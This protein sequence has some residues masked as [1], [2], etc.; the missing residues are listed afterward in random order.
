MRVKLHR[1]S[2]FT[3]VELITVIII[4]GIVS[5]GVTRFLEFG[6]QVYTDAVGRERQLGEARFVIERMTRELREALPNSVRVA[7][8]NGIQCIE[9]VPITGSASYITIPV[10]TAANEVTLVRPTASGDLNADLSGDKIVVY[11][12]SPADVYVDPVQSLGKVF[13]LESL[14]SPIKDTSTIVPTDTGKDAVERLKIR[15]V[16]GAYPNVQ[17]SAYS[18]TSRYYLVGNAVSYCA[19]GD[20]IM[21]YDGYWPGAGAQAVPPAVT[22]VLMA[23]NQLFDADDTDGNTVRPLIQNP[24]PWC[25][26]RW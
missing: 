9:F 15:K 16:A 22:G 1:H 23:K 3:L 21:R 13:Y 26:M 18:P 6:T 19:N 10:E 20:T 25:A 5:I 8:S 24:L 2:G 12:L 7:E 17:F 14:P 4:L 11:P